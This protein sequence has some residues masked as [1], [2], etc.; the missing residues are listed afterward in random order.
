MSEIRVDTISEKTSANGVSI[1]SLAI[2]DGKITNL[3]NATLSA[4]DLGTGVHIKTADSGAGVNANGDE[5]VI[6]GSGNAGMSILAG[7]S[8]KANI[9][10]GDSGSSAIGNISYDHSDNSLSIGVNGA[11]NFKIL[12]TGAAT[13]TT[14][15]NSNTLTLSSTDADANPG[16]VLN[17]YR[18]SGSAADNDYIGR[19]IFTFNN[20]AP[21][22]ETALAQNI[23]MTD[24][25]NG[26]EDVKYVHEQM[27][28]G[29]IVD[30]FSISDTE[31]VFNEASID[32]DFRVESN[33]NTHMLFVD[34]GNDE[35]GVNVSAAEATFHVYSSGTNIAGKFETNSAHGPMVALNN[36]RSDDGSEI[37]L[38]FDRADTVQ[39]A[40]GTNAQGL[41]FWTNSSLTERMRI[42]S[43]GQVG[44]GLT[45]P[46]VKFHVAAAVNGQI[47]KFNNT[48]TSGGTAGG[49]VQYS[50][51]PDD[52]SNHFFYCTDT[53][54]NRLF[55]HSNG[56]VVNHDNSYGQISDERIKQNITDANSQWNDIKSIKVRNFER[57][58]DV[59]QYGVGE[60]VQ[61]GVVAQEVETVSPGLIREGEP[62]AEDIKMSSEFGTLYTSDDAET[63]DGDDAVLYVAE[64]EEVING[65]YEVGDV[66]IPA[67]HSAKVGDIKSLT[68]E[69]VKTV[70]YSVL[71]MKA[72][73]ALQEAMAKI[74][75][76][77]TKVAALEG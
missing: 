46:D 52:S 76:L 47:F 10:L 18:N 38:R 70:S 43:D 64:D 51:A 19:N 12:S 35:V 15:D 30:R 22:I 75:T 72:I 13:I 28:A 58:D 39:G 68:G 59:A 9:F 66:K 61:I 57:K 48:R 71:Y 77:E 42:N 62:M 44:I 2:K 69:K 49:L 26:S 34:A 54:A 27:T 55:I 73:K 17:Y 56:N 6:E 8:S 20:D 53:V 65:E 14:A 23:I 5:L 60:K 63:K 1:D 3:M 7:A 25:S 67:T 11:E 32:S 24:V 33:S 40:I 45:N 50:Y 41:S 37:S 29:S 21:E 31:A 4:A 36:L 16:P 74:E